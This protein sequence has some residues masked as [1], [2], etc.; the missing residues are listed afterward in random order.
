MHDVS[1]LSSRLSAL[2]SLLGSR[3][4]APGSRISDSETERCTTRDSRVDLEVGYCGLHSSGGVGRLLPL[5]A[6]GSCN[7]SYALNVVAKPL[8]CALPLWF[9]FMQVTLSVRQPICI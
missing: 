2:G 4:S 9:R 3:L 8:L 6:Q 7:M 5:E 1:R